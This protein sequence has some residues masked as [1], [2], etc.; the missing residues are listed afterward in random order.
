MLSQSKNYMT[1][2]HTSSIEGKPIALVITC[3]G[4]IEDNADLLP[5]IFGRMARFLKADLID[6]LVVPGCTDT[7]SEGA[8]ERARKLAS[9][10]TG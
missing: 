8:E 10:I 7:P 6:A 4:P 2:E 1:P 5:Q 9:A 3:A